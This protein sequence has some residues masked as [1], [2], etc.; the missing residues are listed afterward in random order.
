MSAFLMSLV[1]LI[2]FDHSQPDDYFRET[3]AVDH[4]GILP[5]WLKPPGAENTQ[6]PRRPEFQKFTYNLYYENLLMEGRL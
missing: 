6:A 4:E 1:S 5:P 3:D 2:I